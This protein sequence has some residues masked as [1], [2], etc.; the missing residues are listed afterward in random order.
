MKA[1]APANLGVVLLQL[2]SQL[3]VTFTHNW[4][5]L[6]SSALRPAQHH[7]TSYIGTSGQPS[8]IQKQA[9]RRS[10]LTGRIRR[11]ATSQ[12]PFCD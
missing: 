5:G 9:S 12:D 1:F 11:S 7:A 6:G 2:A 8:A 10:G 4:T 3:S